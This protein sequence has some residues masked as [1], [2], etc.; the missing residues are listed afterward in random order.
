MALG[1]EMLDE[2]CV[3]GEEQVVQL[4]HAHAHHHVDVQPASQVRTERLHLVWTGTELHITH[5]YSNAP[6]SRDTTVEIKSNHQNFYDRFF[7]LYPARICC[8]CIDKWDLGKLAC[9]STSN[10]VSDEMAF[11]VN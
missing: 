11:Q 3:C 2:V 10:P 7:F 4:V 1:E 6:V 8:N 5:N 9:Q